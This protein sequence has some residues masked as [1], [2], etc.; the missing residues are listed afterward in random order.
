MD[1]TKDGKYTWK[2][3]QKDKPQEFSGSYVVADNLLILKRG[4]TPVMVG[5]VTPLGDG[6]FNFKLPGGNPADPGLTF[7][8]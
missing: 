4:D 3:A 7:G 1:L 5:Q 6:R 2:Y 8:K